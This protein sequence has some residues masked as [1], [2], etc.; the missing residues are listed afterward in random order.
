MNQTIP[1]FPLQ[2]PPG[3][4]RTAAAQRKRAAFGKKGSGYGRSQ[5]SVAEAVKR[6]RAELQRMG[7][8]EFD[9]VVST[10]VP[11]RLDGWPR[12]DREPGD[13]G[14]AVYW[15]ESS[16]DGHPQRC[17]AV[18]IYD[19]VADNLAAVAATLDALR[20]V[21]RHGGAEILDRT[22][23]GFTAIEA[24]KDTDHWSDVLDCDRN[25]STSEVRAAF[26]RARS[27]AHP[28]KQQGG[29][30]ALFNRVMRAYQAF[31]LDHGVSE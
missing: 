11:L 2:W 29:S 21:K 13:P 7:V 16:K 8:R 17:M 28:D 19:R 12:S 9:L 24:P 3:W 14:V 6:V 31:C 5:L 15:R 20:A 22:F 18:D 26:L 27:A 23:T 30:T 25:A 10:N 4:K 1:A